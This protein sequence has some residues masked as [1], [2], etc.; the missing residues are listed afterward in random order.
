MAKPGLIRT[1]EDI[2][3][4]FDAA[5]PTSESISRQVYRHTVCGAWGR[6]ETHTRSVKRR[7]TWRVDLRKS[8][9]G[10]VIAS[11]RRV[12]GGKRGTVKVGEAPE[13]VRSYLE[14]ARSSPRGPWIVAGATD[15]D[16]K[17]DVTDTLTSPD[18]ITRV[19]SRGPLRSLVTFALSVD[20]PGGTETVFT[21]GSIVEGTDAEVT[22]VRITLPCEPKALDRAVTD[23]EAE[24]TRIWNETHGCESCP[25]GVGGPIDPNCASCKGQGVIL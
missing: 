13:R 3:Y 1:I 10:I 17:V 14:A 5:H 25:E 12:K 6:V 23:V 7:E 8:I 15:L 2:A 11:L 19:T 16:F 20:R 9:T 21:V 24:A 22:P 18:G 4:H